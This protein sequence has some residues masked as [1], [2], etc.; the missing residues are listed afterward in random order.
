MSFT[1]WMMMLVAVALTSAGCK[2]E[3]STTKDS[4]KIE[5]EVPKVEVNKTP[6]LDPRTDDDVD[7]KTPNTSNP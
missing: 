3:V 4:V 5:A 2:S 6:D 1:K 7:V